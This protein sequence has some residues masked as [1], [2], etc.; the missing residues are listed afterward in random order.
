MK[1]YPTLDGNG[2]VYGWGRMYLGLCTLTRRE[3]QSDT[4]NEYVSP[5]DC[6]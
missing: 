4:G 5:L 6:H 2:Q 3:A 1:L